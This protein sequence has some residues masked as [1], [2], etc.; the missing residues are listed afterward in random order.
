L[1]QAGLKPDQRAVTDRQETNQQEGQ[2]GR[3][4]ESMPGRAALFSPV[5]S[6][7]HKEK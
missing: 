7:F 3:A 6:D 5:E 4:Q 2:F 1:V